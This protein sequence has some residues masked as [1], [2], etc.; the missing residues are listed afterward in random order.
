MDTGAYDT[1]TLLLNHVSSIAFRIYEPRADPSQSLQTAALEAESALRSKGHIVY[2]D[3]AR[4]LLWYFHIIYKDVPSDTIASLP[5]PDELSVS[6]FALSEQGSIDPGTLHKGRSQNT[7]PDSASPTTL[8][9]SSSDLSARLALPP[10]P[11]SPDQDQNLSKPPRTDFKA[12]SILLNAAYENFIAGLLNTATLKLATTTRAVMLNYR[13]VLLRARDVG[14]AELPTLCTLHAY[15]TTAGSLILRVSAKVC[16][17]LVSMQHS[18]SPPQSPLGHQVLAAPFGLLAV[19]HANGN[20]AGGTVSLAHT[21]ATQAVSIRG[22]LD[23]CGA[24]WRQACARALQLRGVDDSVLDQCAWLNVVIPRRPRDWSSTAPLSWPAPLCFRRKAMPIGT[25]SRV[26]HDLLRGHEESHDPLGQARGWFNSSHEREEKQAA[27]KAERLASDAREADSNTKASRTGGDLSSAIHLARP[28]TATAGHMYPTPP[29]GIQQTAGV[30]PSF[31]TMHMSPGNP[32]SATAGLDVDTEMGNMATET[33]NGE[34]FGQDPSDSEEPSKRDR[35]GSNTL[36]NADN[37]FGDMEAD[38]FGENEMNDIT[39]DDFNFFDEVGEPTA[40]TAPQVEMTETVEAVETPSVVKQEE[41]AEATPMPEPTNNDT[42]QKPDEEP[43]SPVFA[44]PELKHA[45]STQQEEANRNLASR[46]ASVKRESS[47]F[48]PD[49]VFKRVRASLM[50]TSISKPA[51]SADGLER[52]SSVFGKVDFD[53]AMPLINKKYEHGGAYDFGSMS[54]EKLESSLSALPDVESLKKRVKSSK[55]S[56]ESAG[57]LLRRFTAVDPSTAHPSPSKIDDS[58]SDDD[59]SSEDPESDDSSITTEEPSSPARASAKRARP[60]EEIA[61]QAPSVDELDLGEEIEPSLSVEVPRLSRLEK[62]ELRISRFFAEPE[63]LALDIAIPDEDLINMAQILT[64]Q[65]ATGSLEVCDVGLF[66]RKAK[67]ARVRERHVATTARNAMHAIHTAGIQGFE[68]AY[69]GKL[70]D[71]LETQDALVTG[72]PNRMQPRPIPGR[73]PFNDMKVSNFYGLPL[74]HLELKRAETKLSILPTAVTFWE[75]LGLAPVSGGKNVIAACVFPSWKGVS[76]NVSTFLGRLKSMYELLRLGTFSNVELAGEAED[77][78]LPYEIDRISTSP[79]AA[80]TAKGSALVDAMEPLRSAIKT[81]TTSDVNIVLY[82]AY[83]PNNPLSIVEACSAFQNFFDFYKKTLSS[84]RE[85]PRNE[86]VL[87]L[88]SLDALS[89]PTSLVLTPFNELMRLSIETYDRCTSF[90]QPMP[91]PAITLEQPVPRH[92]NFECSPRASASVTHEHS[93]MHI[94]Y[95]QSVDERWVTAAWTDDRGR[96]QATASF[97]LG[98]KGKP[99]STSMNEVAHEIWESTVDLI[100]TWKVQW[101]IVI[102]KCGPMDEDEHKFWVDLARTQDKEKARVSLTLLS[103]ET[104][105]S[106]QVFPAAAKIPQSATLLGP[107]PVSTP[108]ASVLSPDQV[109]TPATPVRDPTASA[110]SN[111]PG[112]DAA[113]DPE[114]DSSLLDTTDQ[115]WVALVGHRMSIS[116]NAT[117]LQPALLSGYLLKRTGPNID[118]TPAI[119]EV[120]LVH[121]DISPRQYETSLREILSWYGALGTLARARGVVARDTDV[122]PWHIAAA[123]KAVRA[124]YLLL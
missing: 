117:E 80:M 105:P 13:T 110:S 106:M 23:H 107:T 18:G 35:S 118:E 74:P 10:K 84:K 67:V 78:L 24:E 12:S 39:E 98:R 89:S 6:L 15:M 46:G 82:F 60:E 36:D 124:L 58:A 111:T 88:V 113:M 53:P 71:V 9:T 38:I 50:A 19:D 64:E 17:G 59:D 103:V 63:P 5:A 81:M 34:A 123:E 8:A 25:T 92:I 116:P 40:P 72:Q 27:R 41:K 45:R 102:A 73:E 114:P 75:S 11:Q 62:P 52:K 3:T 2:Y 29:D 87:Q 14:G 79:D 121:V 94:A 65:A 1:N 37:M 96:Q 21:P 55:K 44:K 30:T 77:G 120:N 108:Q 109:A 56:R 54:K 100:S 119:L 28:G 16:E 93:S 91:A 69:G 31:D 43:L 47:P 42:N 57:T 101:R 4:G 70:K 68:H 33:K 122:R 112:G 83:S 86:L 32:P 85:L 61:S 66:E 90:T 97:C 95:A 49:T 20:H 26:D 115:T 48:N 51:P 7:A 99:L 104:D 22:Q 76:D